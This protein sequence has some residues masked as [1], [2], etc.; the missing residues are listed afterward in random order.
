MVIQQIKSLI[1]LTGPLTLSLPVISRVV[2]VCGTP[3]T[4]DLG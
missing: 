3:T 1:D 4:P 2:M